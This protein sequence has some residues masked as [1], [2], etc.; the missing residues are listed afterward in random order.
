MIDAQGA[1]EMMDFLDHNVSFSAADEIALELSPLD[2]LCI[3]WGSVLSQPKGMSF[4]GFTQEKESYI[5]LLVSHGTLQV[6]LDGEPLIVR[7]GQTLVIVP[8]ETVVG[9][10]PHETDIYCPWLAFR[11]QRRRPG[12]RRMGIR[13][14]RVAN[15]RD[16]R[17][18]AELIAL[19]TE[20]YHE[21]QI[22][23][24]FRKLSVRSSQYLLLSLLSR[25]DLSE[26]VRPQASSQS[27][28][29]AER[30]RDYVRMHAHQHITSDIVAK[31][32]DCSGGYL[33][34]AF[35]KTYGEGIRDYLLR[36]RMQRARWSLINSRMSITQVAGTCGFNDLNYFTRLFTR[37][38]GMSPSEYR[39]A[40]GHQRVDAAI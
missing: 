32:L 35:R 11:F 39:A 17:R 12:A 27:A 21:Y 31:A 4:V 22:P 24:E 6:E 2:E 8:G 23:G 33:R 34:V 18:I 26:S 30:A 25:L 14:P 15:T 10:A 16:S 28:V 9:T 5:L 7:Q 3:E 13:I 38:H 36:H 19:V 37:A 1:V 40:H 29:L 20:D